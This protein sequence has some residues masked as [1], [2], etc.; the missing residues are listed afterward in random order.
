MLARLSR[1]KTE[2]GLKRRSQRFR[3]C[4]ST[5]CPTT[6][7]PISRW[8]RSCGSKGHARRG[9]QS[10]LQTSLEL[11]QPFNAIDWRLL[12]ELGITSRFDRQTARRRSSISS[13]SSSSSPARQ[14]T[15]FPPD[16]AITLARLYES[17]GRPG[18]SGGHVSS[19]QPRRRP[20]ERHARYH[21]EAG[22]LLRARSASTTRLGGC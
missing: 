19:A 9:P 1:T 6:T 7:G 18:P 13:R 3:R 21:Y 8:A 5:R 14:V 17:D 4:R 12:E 20:R 10:V 22:R 2:A 15:D 16:T 11:S